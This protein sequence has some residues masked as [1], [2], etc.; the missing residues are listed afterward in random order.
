MLCW[1]TIGGSIFN[2]DNSMVSALTNVAEVPGSP[3]RPIRGGWGLGIPKNLSKK[4]KDAAWMV[5][6]YITSAEFDKYQFDKHQTDPNRLSTYNDKALNAKWP[7]LKVAGKAME[8][9]NILDVAVIPEC[10]ELVG[11]AAREFNLAILGTQSVQT[12]CNNA[13]ASWEKI[14]RRAGHLK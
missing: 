13:Q 12:A 11:E 5:M 10:F 2:K 3:G 7:Y 6:Q 8:N 4:R 1:S 14:L 9:G